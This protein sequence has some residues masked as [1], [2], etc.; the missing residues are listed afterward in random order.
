VGLVNDIKPAGEIVR[1]MM[2]EAKRIIE[3]LGR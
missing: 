3:M 2:A 1:G